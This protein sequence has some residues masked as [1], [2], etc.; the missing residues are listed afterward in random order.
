MELPFDLIDLIDCFEIVE[1]EDAFLVTVDCLLG[2]DETFE[3]FLEIVDTLDGFLSPC[4]GH[5]LA[6]P[7]KIL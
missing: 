2:R 6:V 7:E 1:T 3:L 4:T 5:E